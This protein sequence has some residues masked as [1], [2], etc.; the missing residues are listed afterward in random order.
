MRAYTVGIVLRSPISHPQA[1]ASQDV[2]VVS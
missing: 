1:L 2:L